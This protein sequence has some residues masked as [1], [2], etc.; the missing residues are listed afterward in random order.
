MARDEDYFTL[1]FSLPAYRSDPGEDPID[2]S[3][4]LIT[5]HSRVRLIPPF[6]PPILVHRDDSLDYV[7]RP[8]LEARVPLVQGPFWRPWSVARRAPSPRYTVGREI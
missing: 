4:V 8:I 6:S 3:Y 2:R 5:D 7:A 1:S